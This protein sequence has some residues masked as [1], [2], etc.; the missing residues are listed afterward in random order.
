MT[1]KANDHPPRDSRPA[2]RGGRLPLFS[3]MALPGMLTEGLAQGLQGLLFR[4]TSTREDGGDM[5]LDQDRALLSPDFGHAD[6]VERYGYLPGLP[7]KNP[8]ASEEVLSRGRR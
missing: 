1:Q 5:D 2:A 3:L 7:S 8:L 4:P 6:L